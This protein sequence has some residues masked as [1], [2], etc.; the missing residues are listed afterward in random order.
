M[1]LLTISSEFP[2]GPGGIGTHAYHLCDELVERGWDVRVLTPQDYS[3]PA[4]IETFNAAQRFQVCGLRSEQ[5]RW[6]RGFRRWCS[7]ARELNLFKPQAVVASG[8]RS[9]WLAAAQLPRLG[10]PWLAIGHGI[11]FGVRTA[12]QHRITR[13]AIQRASSVVCVSQFTWDLMIEAGIRPRGGR[14]IPNGADSASFRTLPAHEI[15]RFRAGLGFNGAKLLLTV[16]NVTERKGQRITIEAL[17]QVLQQCPDVH[18]LVAGLPSK[19]DEYQALAKSLG[20]A[21]RVH[22]LG[23]LNPEDLVRYLNACDLF[24][25]TSV[26]TAEGDCEGFGIAVVEAALCGKP[27]VVSANCGLAEAVADGL[28]GLCVPERNPQATAQAIVSLLRD[29]ARRVALA[30]NAALRAQQEQ[31]WV[32][33][34]AEYDVLLKDLV[35]QSNA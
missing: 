26:R 8:Q 23:R 35:G 18:Y 4:E 14:V 3:S 30:R 32:H 21:E 10:I 24:V 9:V 1:R 27:A 12:W 6:L 25:M 34:A 15:A 16:G 20:V 29:D 5:P 7:L 31:T 11:E 17:P 33:R 28:T 19:R 2:P 13:W 22:F